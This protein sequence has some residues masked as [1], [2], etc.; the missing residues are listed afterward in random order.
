MTLA[1]PLSPETTARLAEK[2]RLAGMDTPSYAAKLLERDVNRTILEEISGEL[3]ERFNQ[4]G[5]TE[6]ELGNLLEKEKHEARERELGI[7]F[8]E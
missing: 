3:A 6:E 2:A 4:T 5:M 8:S 7:K 1:V